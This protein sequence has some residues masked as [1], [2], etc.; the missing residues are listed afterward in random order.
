MGLK[1]R[2]TGGGSNLSKN[3][4]G[5]NAA[6]TAATQQSNLHARLNGTAGYSLD[7]SDFINVNKSYQEYTDGVPNLLPAPSTLDIDGIT[8]KSALITQRTNRLNNTF[9]KGTYR[10]NPPEGAQAF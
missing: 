3:N 10:D 6:L 5:P 9:S 7:G 8:P 1:E 4:G 2:L